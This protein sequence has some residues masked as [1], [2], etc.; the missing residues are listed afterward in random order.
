MHGWQRA[1]L[2]GAIVLAGEPA[3]ALQPLDA[4]LVGARA[5]APDNAEAR[6]NLERQRAEASVARGRVLPGVSV[7]GTYTRN[8]YES[9]VQLPATGGGPPATVTVT[10]RD[11]LVGAATVTVPLVDLSNLE[12]AV[13]ARTSAGALDAQQRSTA[14]QVESVVAQDYYQ[15]IANAALVEASRR[16]V[17]V[18]KVS[19]RIANER[20]AAGTA[21]LL[22]VDRARAEVESDLQQLT[23]AELQVAI[24]ARAL[25]S[26]TG[27]TPELDD[28]GSLADDLH[29][30]GPLDRFEPPD[31]ALPSL[32]AA[33]RSR[34]SAEQQATAQRLSL[35]PRVVGSFTEQ[36]TNTS[37]FAGHDATWQATLGLT[38]SFDFTT[39]PAIRSEEASADA[40]R[41]RERRARL[42]ARDAI[43]DAWKTVGA[44]I[45]RGRSARAQAEASSEASA[46]ALERYRAGTATQLDL[47][48]AQRDAFT[49]DAS[50]IQADAN[51]VN[52][53]AQLRIAAGTSLLEGGG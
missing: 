24:V 48:Q 32:L 30:E 42:A 23:G 43:H 37:G 46:Q 13:A 19:L 6:A 47:L 14:L 34:A 25:Q 41:A 21:A 35:L 29:E 39:L 52:S 11:Q 49:A 40:A 12:R 5:Y 44:N 3:S 17:D 15:L 26:L 51:L 31:D 28:R 27:V 45:A 7:A 36:E 8:Q 2:V 16:A 1:L 53:R 50:R 33:T 18:A 9:K 22:E 4:F 20:R 10:P 38:W